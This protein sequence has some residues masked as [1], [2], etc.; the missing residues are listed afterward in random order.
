MPDQ[1]SGGHS[2]PAADNIAPEHSTTAID[3]AAATD[4]NVAETSDIDAAAPEPNSEGTTDPPS[5]DEKPQIDDAE[6]SD[7]EPIPPDPTDPTDHEA[8]IAEADAILGDESPFRPQLQPK[9]HQTPNIDAAHAAHRGSLLPEAHLLPE[10]AIPPHVHDPSATAGDDSRPCRRCGEPATEENPLLC[11]CSCSPDGLG[12]IQAVV[13]AKWSI[14]WY[15]YIRK[16]W[17]LKMSI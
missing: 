1:E 12:W 14:L 4:P 5:Y 11:V 6:P 10:T 13:G 8:I 3:D 2:D 9:F 16:V 7:P 15:L 17:V